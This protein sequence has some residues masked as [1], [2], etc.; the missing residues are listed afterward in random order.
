MKVLSHYTL[1]SNTAWITHSNKPNK[2]CQAERP[3][4]S[5][6]LSKKHTLHSCTLFISRCFCHRTNRFQ[7]RTCTNTAETIQRTHPTQEKHCDDDVSVSEYIR[8]FKCAHVSDQLFRYNWALL[9]VSHMILTLRTLGLY[10]FIEKYFVEP[11]S[12]RLYSTATMNIHFAEQVICS[13]KRNFYL[14]EY[15]IRYLYY[16]RY[17]HTHKK[18]CIPFGWNTLWYTVNPTHDIS[19][20]LNRSH[21]SLMLFMWLFK[22]VYSTE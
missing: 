9:Y 8:P 2:I 6:W 7:R 18:P 17:T 14:N 5:G 16:I 3:T 22:C 12:F 4:Q 1:F 13:T 11:N 20:H 21:F 19:I 15:F 10:S